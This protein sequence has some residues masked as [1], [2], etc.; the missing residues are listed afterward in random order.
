VFADDTA[1]ELASAA[2]WYV[3]VFSTDPVVDIAAFAIRVADGRDDA[4]DARQRKH[5]EAM[6][7]LA[8]KMMA[9]EQEP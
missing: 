4:K 3:G 6:A 2:G 1:R 7:A 9:P 8:K 5:D